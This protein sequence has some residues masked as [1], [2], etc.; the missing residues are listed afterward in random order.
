[1]SKPTESELDIL[2]VIW[3]HGPKS[4]KYVHN[5]INAS[6]NVGY[7]T[8]LKQMQVMTEKGLLSRTK[9]ARKHIYAATSGEQETQKG[10][11]GKF[12]KSAFKGSSAALVM[13][14]LGNYQP[15]ADEL[16]KIKSLIKNL[17]NK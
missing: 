16:A 10:L 3:N 8:V 15:S 13:Q 1:M 5:I 6:K 17:E 14:A 11:L 7:T 9:E 2:R 4:V 12:I